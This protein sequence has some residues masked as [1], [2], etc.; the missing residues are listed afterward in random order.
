MSEELTVPQEV[1]DKFSEVFSKDEDSSQGL[2]NADLQQQQDAL[3]QAGD[4]T[5]DGIPS[6]KDEESDHAE[7]G[8]E[9]DEAGQDDEPQGDEAE[10]DPNE[11]EQEQVD[12]ALI[13]IARLNNFSEEDIK[14]LVGEYGAGP[15]SAMLQKLADATDETTRQ[16]A[17]SASAQQPSP[18]PP[19]QAAPSNGT[20]ESRDSLGVIREQFGDDVA[21]ALVKHVESLVRPIQEQYAAQTEAQQAQA[22]REELNAVLDP[23]NERTKGLYT[24]G[25]Q[26]QQ[27]L[28]TFA[29]QIRA[30][31]AAQGR[32]VSV[33]EAIERAHRIVGKDFEKSE[34]RKEIVSQLKKRTPTAKPTRSQ[35][36]TKP[37]TDAAALE[38]VSQKMLSMGMES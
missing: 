3:E 29:D 34:T 25:S 13:D 7:D 30:G 33:R 22:L 36:T 17:Q 37:G 2:V 14:G 38:A 8:I 10:G 1:T 23:L 31:A 35:R 18:T 20:S 9:Q 11:Q 27:Q 32:N 21:D 15:V 4:V 26:M 12:E 19:G 5:P 6:D 28:L 16:L 24:P